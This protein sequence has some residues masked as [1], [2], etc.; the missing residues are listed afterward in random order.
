MEPFTFVCLA[1]TAVS[2]SLTAAFCRR[3][4]LRHRK[5]GWHFGVLAAFGT[6]ILTVL[7]VFQADAF[8]PQSWLGFGGKEGPALGCFLVTGPVGLIPSLLVV[9]YFRSKAKKENDAA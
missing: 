4:R 1:V 2:A 6:A 7:L 3:A 9:L 5:A 8:R